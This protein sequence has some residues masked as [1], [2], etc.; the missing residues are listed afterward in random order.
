MNHRDYNAHHAWGDKRSR[1]GGR[2]PKREPVT[3]GCVWPATALFVIVLALWGDNA[4]EALAA[5]PRI[6]GV[7]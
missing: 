7:M 2:A 6:L 5:I 4:V 3:V 1:T